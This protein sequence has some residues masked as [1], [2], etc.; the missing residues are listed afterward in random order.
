MHSAQL[1]KGTEKYATVE[2]YSYIIAL[3]IES[4]KHGLNDVTSWQY[5]MCGQTW[6]V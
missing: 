5:N 2:G 1:F 6:Y 4:T 3:A